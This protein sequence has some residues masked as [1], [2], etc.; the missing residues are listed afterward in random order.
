M[1]SIS[2]IDIA[3]YVAVADLRD[4][5]GGGD[6]NENENENAR[7]KTLLSSFPLKFPSGGALG[8]GKKPATRDETLMVKWLSK[9]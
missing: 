3:G 9:E 5:A 8:F 6:A 1:N 4:G 2:P 7:T